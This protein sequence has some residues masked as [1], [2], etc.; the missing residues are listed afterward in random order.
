MG[1]SKQRVDQAIKGV[2]K[3]VTIALAVFRSVELS[4]C[5]HAGAGAFPGA[6]VQAPCDPVDRERRFRA[7]SGGDLIRSLVRDRR[8]SESIADR[9]GCDEC[10]PRGTALRA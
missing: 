10:D 1:P 7:Q 6:E 5:M 9:G 2:I 8:V 4:S 3:G